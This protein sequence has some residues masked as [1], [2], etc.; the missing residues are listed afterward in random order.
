MKLIL[1]DTYVMI[2]YILVIVVTLVNPF[3]LRRI[4]RSG[5]SR[6][7]SGDVSYLCYDNVGRLIL[8]I[9]S[10]LKWVILSYTSKSDLK[11]SCLL[12]VRTGAELTRGTLQQVLLSRIS[13]ITAQFW[14]HSCGQVIKGCLGWGRGP[15][16]KL[17]N[18]I[19]IHKAGEVNLVL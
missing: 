5:C 19:L 12:I 3:S 18:L 4:R 14:R 11:C 9:E 13:W 8:F 16:N 2:G 6:S 17:K 10:L 7:W 15:L 1:V